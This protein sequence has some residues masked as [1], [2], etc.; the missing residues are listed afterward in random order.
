[1]SEALQT[2]HEAVDA[3]ARLML[4]AGAD[5]ELIRLVTDAVVVNTLWM[6]RV[7][8]EAVAACAAA[9]LDA[10]AALTSLADTMLQLRAE[11]QLLASDRVKRVTH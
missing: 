8:A 9:G 10:P 6:T 1:M 4:P 5:P 2:V 3:A 7:Y 11:A